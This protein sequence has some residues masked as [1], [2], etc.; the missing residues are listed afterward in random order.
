[1][2]SLRGTSAM[3]GAGRT[4][5]PLHRRRI[6]EGWPRRPPRCVGP[7][8]P[9]P[10]ADSRAPPAV[11]L[12]KVEVWLAAALCTDGCMSAVK[13]HRVH[14]AQVR[15]LHHSAFQA[16]IHSNHDGREFQGQAAHRTWP[17]MQ[18]HA[19]RPSDRARPAQALLRILPPGAAQALGD[20]LPPRTARNRAR[21][22]R[23]GRALAR[24]GTG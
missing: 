11:K 17:P 3:R 15:Q 23:A 1:M 10:Q 18:L 8:Q 7:A 6:R 5:T 20:D 24:R 2:T 16:P 19:A 4:P 21:F 12:G 14:F 22:G 9:Q 13:A